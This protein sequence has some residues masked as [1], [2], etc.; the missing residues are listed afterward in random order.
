MFF[1]RLKNDFINIE[2][3]KSGR[4][5]NLTQ[6]SVLAFSNGKTYSIFFHRKEKKKCFQVLQQRYGRLRNWYLKIFSAL[7]F[8]LKSKKQSE[9]SSWLWKHC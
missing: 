6:D 5:E 8:L 4:V 7:L 1:R 9:G 2:I 3:D